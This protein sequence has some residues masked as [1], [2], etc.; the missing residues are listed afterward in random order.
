MQF[1]LN[2]EE[3]STSRCRLHFTVAAKEVKKELDI[4]YTKFQ[5]EVSFKGF[6]KGKVPRWLLEKRLSDR[7]NADVANKIVQQAYEN[8]DVPHVVI[9]RPTVEELGEIVKNATLS[10]TIGVDIRPNITLDNYLGLEIEYEAPEVADDEIE[11]AIQD[12]LRSKGRIDDAPDDVAI[13]PN[14]FVLVGLKIV[15]GEETLVDESGTMIN[16]GKEQFYPGIEALLLGM[17]KG[18]I[19][20]EKLTIGE[21]SVFEHLRGKEGDATIE[22]NSLQTYV[23]PDLTDELAAEFGHEGGVEEFKGAISDGLVQQ[24]ENAARDQARVKILQKLVSANKFDVP[25]AMV[26]EQLKA[27]MEELQMR[28]VYAGEDPRKINFSDAEIKDLTGRAEF[29]AKSACVLAAVAKQE[30]LGV[31]DTDIDDKVNE[32]A[33][34]RGQ[35]VEAIRAYIQSEDAENVLKERI[36]EEKTLNWIF[37]KSNLVAP[38][39]EEV[40]EAAEPAANEKKPAKKK[41]A[42]KKP[43]AKKAAAKKA[44]AK[45]PAAKKKAAAKKTAAKKPAAKKAAAKKPAKKKPA[46]KKKAAAKKTKKA[47]SKK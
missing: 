42:A 18:E 6:R 9:G 41:A 22:V 26:D 28:R 40:L 30:N 46:A 21:A 1:D 7:V 44:S 39:P 31:D 47:D 2:I 34:M 3:Q 5:Q 25:K 16:M 10:F 19:K 35:T 27:L 4:T 14:D 43:A 38:K 8:A 24:R 23:V 11:K 17:K 32:I 36:L 13:G 15:S 20:S 45:K 37:D 12:K 29:A 33:A